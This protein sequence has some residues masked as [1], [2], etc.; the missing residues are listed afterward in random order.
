[1]PT[2]LTYTSLLTDLANYAER[3]TSSTN[4]PSVVAQ[5]PRIINNTERRLARELKILGT[6][7]SLNWTMQVGLQAYQKPDRWRKNVSMAIG[8]GTPAGVGNIYTPIFE[9]AYEFVRLYGGDVS[10]TAQPKYYGDVDYQHW[11]FQ[12]TPDAAYPVST[13]CWMQPTLL[14]ATNTTNFWTEYTPDALLHL[15]LEELFGFLKNQPLYQLWQGEASRDISALAN[16]DLQAILD[17]TQAR[18]SA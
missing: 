7:E 10:A 3:S 2:Y 17:R 11:Y 8:V 12:P 13:L 15:C 1:M 14:D 6:I 16:Q 9:R 18:K 4:D 5:L